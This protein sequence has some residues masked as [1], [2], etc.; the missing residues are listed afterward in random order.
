MAQRNALSYTQEDEE[1]EED[2]D[3]FIV[4]LS[5]GFT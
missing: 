3:T 2:E 1:E 4:G 5:M